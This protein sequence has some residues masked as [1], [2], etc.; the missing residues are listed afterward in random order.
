MPYTDATISR[1]HRYHTAV[2]TGLWIQLF[3][4]WFFIKSNVSKARGSDQRSTAYPA[5]LGGPRCPPCMFKHIL[6]WKSRTVQ[7]WWDQHLIP[8]K[9]TLRC[10]FLWPL[11][12]HSH[13]RKLWWYTKY[14]NKASNK[15]Y[16][17]RSNPLYFW[18]SHQKSSLDQTKAV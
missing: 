8:I 10:Q 5:M 7:S 11:R 13:A 14:I 17:S 12:L 6:F 1:Q 16:S 18:A 2:S 4:C 9:N 15:R 3:V